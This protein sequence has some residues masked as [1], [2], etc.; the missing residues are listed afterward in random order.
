MARKKYFCA[1]TSELPPE[2]LVAHID[3]V[4]SRVHHIADLKEQF[5][6]GEWTE[7]LEALWFVLNDIHRKHMRMKRA[8]E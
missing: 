8:L 3:D 6:A 7:E 4:H 2:R 1:I 5:K